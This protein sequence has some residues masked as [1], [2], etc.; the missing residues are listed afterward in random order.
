MPP[1]RGPPRAGPAPPR[2]EPR[3]PAARRARRPGPG[4]RRPA[5]PDHPWVVTGPRRGE[6][7]PR[8]SP[9]A[10]LVVD[11]ADRR[12]QLVDP[13]GGGQVDRPLVGH[14]RGQGR[15]ERL[16]AQ[17]D[18]RPVVEHG[19]PGRQAGGQ[20][21]GPEQAG[22]EAVDRRDERRLGV[23]CRPPVAE[24]VQSPSDPL[25]Q[26]PGR[27]LGERDG[28]DP[29]RSHP[30]LV[31]RPDEALDEDGRLA[32]PGVGG[33][34]HR[35]PTSLDRLLLLVGEV[36]TRRR[37]G[38]GVG[39]HRPAAR[40]IDGWRQTPSRVQVAGRG[41]SP[42]ARSSRAARS[43]RSSAPASTDSSSSVDTLSVA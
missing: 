14:P 35:L 39:G 41:S 43:A 20:R 8:A 13:A 36:G 29:R 4:G 26:L 21:M 3:P 28:E 15:L 31:D 32:A 40:Q 1:A 42:P 23:P 22:A 27:P 6:L 2:P 16:L 37:P 38:H 33:Q 34:E 11:R 10:E 5:P 12:R 17:A 18:G 30:V 9:A 19:E 7:R 24:L 25:A